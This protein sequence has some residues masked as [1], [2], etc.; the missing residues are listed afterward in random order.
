MSCF[1]KIMGFPAD[2]RVAAR[3]SVYLVGSAVAIQGS[4]SVVIENVSCGG[5]KVCGRDLPGV[6]RQVLLWMDGVD[7]LASVSWAKF[8]ERGLIF[9][10]S[11]EPAA[12]TCLEE[13]AAQGT[14]GA[15]QLF[16]MR[17]SLQSVKGLR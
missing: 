3:R 17:R 4:K 1:G 11:I 2:P 14:V 9:D 10:E 5:A 6:G 12:I 8:G 16:S 7:V 15:P 13:Q